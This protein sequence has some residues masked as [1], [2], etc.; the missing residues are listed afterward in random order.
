LAGDKEFTSLRRDRFN[1][2]LSGRT[3][4]LQDWYAEHDLI[5]PTLFAL[6]ELF[7]RADVGFLKNFENALPMH[8]ADHHV[9]FFAT[10][11]TRKALDDLDSLI[12]AQAQIPWQEYDLVIAN[13]RGYLRHL[14]RTV[15]GSTRFIVYQHD[16]LPFLWRADVEA[17]NV[18]ESA[19]LLR[20]QEIDLEFGAGIN[21]TI[22][23]NFAL[24]NT[25]AAMLRRDVPLAYPLIDQSLFFPDPEVLPE[26]FLASDAVDVQ[27]LAHLVSCIVDKLVILGEAKPDKL[28]RELKPDNIFYT[29]KLGIYD[30]AYYV[31]GAKAL[32]CGETK[33]LSHL[34]LAALKSGIPIITHPTQGMQEFLSD[35]EI[36]TELETASPDEILGHIRKYRKEKTDR[37]K[38]A[39]S[40]DWLNKKYFMRRMRKAFEKER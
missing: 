17:L 38:I 10:R 1:S 3:L 5:N 13:T 19:A 7:P 26:Y 33:V 2:V 37:E 28:L 24:R 8:L 16:L 32:I 9:S 39:S 4:I 20:S 21:L 25:L 22:A 31:A 6:L 23:A 40:V 14:R 27:K 11:L 12:E 15:S 29:G 34:P 30:Q 35:G 18:A 36:G